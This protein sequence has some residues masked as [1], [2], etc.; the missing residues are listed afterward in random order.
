MLVGLRR[1]FVI[2]I[3]ASVAFVLALIRFEDAPANDCLGTAP[4]DASYSLIFSAPPSRDAVDYRVRVTR[5]GA[6]V[7]GARVCMNVA[8]G[9]M[10]AM[11]QI[12][13]ARE[14]SPGTYEARASWQ[15]GGPFEGTA[16]VKEPGKSAVNIPIVFNVL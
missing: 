11:G 1:L 14:V 4:V 10:S 3:V 16:L 15:M 13:R 7:V 6:P 9:G 5:D 2:G 8:M 12:N